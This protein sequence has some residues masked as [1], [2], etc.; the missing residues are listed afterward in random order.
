MSVPHQNLIYRVPMQCK[1]SSICW[2]RAGR[3]M[4]I[5]S[6]FIGSET[7]T[8]HIR[9]LL[10]V[11]SMQ[12]PVTGA[13]RTQIPPSKPKRE[14]TNITNSQNIT[15]TEQLSGQLFPKRWALSN[16]NRTK[17]NVNKHKVKCHRNPDT[18]NRQQNHNKTNPFGTVSNEILE[19]GRVS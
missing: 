19:R 2:L 9:Y 8:V 7:H 6:F 15:A 1:V 4:G 13:I 5:H 17:N 14:T 16:P 3:P 10:K 11:T 12:L 18:K